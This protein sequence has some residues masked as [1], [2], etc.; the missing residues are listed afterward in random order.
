MTEDYDYHLPIGSLMRYFRNDIKKF[1]S[2]KSFLKVNENLANYHERN[3]IL[4]N[5]FKKRV[6]ICWR[7]GLLD[8][9]RN[10]N[11]FVIEDL[12]PIL[13]NKNFDF[14]N[15]QYDNC[16]EELLRIENLCKI[17]IIR[18][19]ELDLK[20]DIN[21]VIALISRLDF[22]ITVDTAVMPIAASIG[23]Q[24]LYVGKK[25]WPNLGTSYYPFF[26]SVECIS[27]SEGQVVS[28]CIPM[29]SSRLLDLMV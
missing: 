14:I 1:N 27:P 17:D 13:T 23:K 28:D 18:W 21:S 11:Y 15:L 5:S 6:G 7:S 29:L 4:K 2:N 26:P 24:V 20:N 22:V 19:K 3:L 16:E 8:F 9:E 25:G 12:I 10:N